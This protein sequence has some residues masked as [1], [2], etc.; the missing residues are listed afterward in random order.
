MNLRCQVDE[1]ARAIVQ[2]DGGVLFNLRTGRFYA[3]NRVGAT[4][5]RELQDSRTLSREELFSRLQARWKN[6]EACRLWQDVDRFVRILRREG[7]VG[8]RGENSKECSSMRSLPVPE[9]PKVSGCRVRKSRSISRFCHVPIMRQITAYWALMFVGG[10]LR[11]GG[12]HALRKAVD[13]WP[14][15]DGGARTEPTFVHG[16]QRPGNTRVERGNCADEHPNFTNLAIYGV[17][18]SRPARKIDLQASVK[19]VEKAAAWCWGTPACLQKSAALVW[20][21]RRQ[22]VPAELVI[23]CRRRPFGAHAWVEVA[24]TIINEQDESLAQFW[25]L[26]R[27]KPAV[28]N[29][30]SDARS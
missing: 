9:R 27:H 10:L 19:H 8:V 5:W 29:S 3:L 15:R 26:D 20:L 17:P 13:G 23:G 22:G 2:S 24:G 18:E 6:V 7:L 14:V 28:A 25:I 1:D 30:I 16:V 11:A 21:L 12:F 4:I